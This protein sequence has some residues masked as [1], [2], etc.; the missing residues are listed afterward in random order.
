MG[1]GSEHT[2]KKGSV[3]IG[4]RKDEEIVEEMDGNDRLRELRVDFLE[5]LLMLIRRVRDR[6]GPGIASSSVP[7]GH[8]LT[9]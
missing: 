2:V 5:I 8:R 9:Q 7:G 1:L 3:G 6:Q 4:P